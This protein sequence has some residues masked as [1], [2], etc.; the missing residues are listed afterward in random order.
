MRFFV[1]F[2]LL[3]SIA[4]AVATYSA[5]DSQQMYVSGSDL[6]SVAPTPPPTLAI[7]GWTNVTTALDATGT[8]QRIDIGGGNNDHA[9][10]T[11]F[12][13][14]T[15]TAGSVVNIFHRVQPYNTKLVIVKDGTEANPIIF[16]GVTDGSGNRPQINCAG[17]TTQNMQD[18]N[19]TWVAPYG[20]WVLTYSRDDGVYGDSTEWNEF[21]NL[22]MYGAGP[23]NTSDGAVAYVNG[24]APIRFNE[25]DHIKLIG[26]IFRDNGNGL[27]MASGNRANGDFHIQGNKFIGNGVDGSFLEHNLYFQAVSDRPFS[28]IV[29]GNYF[30]PLRAGALGNSAMKH[31]GTD[32]IFRYNVVVCDERCLDLVEVQDSLPDYVF[33]NFSAQEILD[34][35]RTSYI[36]GNQFF[37]DDS[38]GLYAAYGIHVGMDTGTGHPTDDQL[39]SSSHGAAEN[40]VMAR[41]V[42]SPVYFYNNSYYVNNASSYYQSIFDTDAGS[43]GVSRHPSEIV[44]ANNIIYFSDDEAPNQIYASHMRSSGQL[45]Y[46]AKNIAYISGSAY[47]TLNE[48]RDNLDSDDPNITIIGASSPTLV[49]GLTGLDPL[50]TDVVNADLEQ[51]DLSLQSGSSAIGQGAA[52]PSPMSNFPVLLQPNLPSNG[53]GA[54]TRSTTDNLGAFE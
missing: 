2:L 40:N 12:D 38:R 8:G 42:G 24:A 18:G 51:I 4:L 31:R 53:G 47:P 36:Y 28:N 5:T 1:L 27:F 11:T 44:A 48:G 32:L 49:Q 7:N 50:F 52:L 15:L 16:N 25:A 22:E 6:V 19:A 10:L 45:T 9:D 54:L 37:A 33:T 39:F 20:C 13:P 46:V 14:G 23:E 34:R 29:E 41:G 43:S 3:P 21:R 35:Y 26:N 30:G 17:A